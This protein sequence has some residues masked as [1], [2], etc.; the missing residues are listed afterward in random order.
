MPAPA[1][2]P[3]AAARSARV[4][5]ML[6]AILLTTALLLA[7]CGESKEQKAEKKVCAARTAIAKEVEHLRSLTPSSAALT[8]VRD[9]VT[10]I[11]GELKQIANAAKDLAPSRKQELVNATEEFAKKFGE[12]L[13]SVAKGSPAT[14]AQAAVQAALTGLKTAYEQALA[15]VK[16]SS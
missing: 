3:I 12:S 15:P 13:A 5:A 6:G 10:K 9:G 1:P 16:C 14:Q 8:E 7:G 11:G 2:G 4:L